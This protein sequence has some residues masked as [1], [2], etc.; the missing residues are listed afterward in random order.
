MTVRKDA[1]V[2]QD[3]RAFAA[4]LDP[5]GIGTNARLP[6]LQQSWR[7]KRRDQRGVIGM[8]RAPDLRQVPRDAFCA[9]ADRPMDI[10]DGHPT[11]TRRIP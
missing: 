11:F 1:A 6:V 8:T 9:D 3:G 5:R 2:A 10:A 4:F 7:G